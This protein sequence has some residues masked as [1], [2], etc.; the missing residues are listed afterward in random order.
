MPPTCAACC[1]RCWGPR[2]SCSPEHFDPVADRDVLLRLENNVRLRL[3]I[4]RT[5]RPRAQSL[6][7]MLVIAPDRPVLLFEAGELNARLDKRRAAMAAFERFLD[8]EGAAGDPADART[9]VEPVAGTA[10]A[11]LLKA[12][13]AC[14]ACRSVQ[15]RGSLP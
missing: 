14:R 4:A 1:A 6:D 15:S 9:R 5:G 7:R 13:I 3:A 2:P 8:I 10:P 11:G 12:G